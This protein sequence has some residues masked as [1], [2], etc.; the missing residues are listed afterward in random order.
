MEL[1][2]ET[3]DIIF[4]RINSYITFFNKRDINDVHIPLSEL[5]CHTDVYKVLVQGM[6]ERKFKIKTNLKEQSCGSDAKIVVN[7]SRVLHRPVI[8]PK[9]MKYHRVSRRGTEIPMEVV[10]YPRYFRY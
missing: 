6:R 10:Q 7:W 3:I 5:N 9:P 4:K 1:T 8:V 2:F